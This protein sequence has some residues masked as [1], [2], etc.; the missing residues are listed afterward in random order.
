MLDNIPSSL[1]N[2]FTDTFPAL[3][4]TSG[5]IIGAFII[6]LIGYI[7]AK[8]V[9]RFVKNTLDALKIEK[10]GEKIR[11]VDMFA[12]LDFE[13]SDILSK[14]VFWLV[15]FLAIIVAT[16][17]LALPVISNGVGAIVAFLP[18]VLSALVIF[19]GGTFI[20][21]M[22]KNLISTTTQS[23]NIGAGKVIASIAFFFMVLIFAIM[24]LSQIGMPTEIMEK[25]LVI[26]IVAFLGAVA[27]GYG[28]SSKDLMANSVAGMYTKNK[29]KVG[30]TI[31]YKE[32]EGLIVDMDNNSATI[33]KDS[34]SKIVI[35]LSKFLTE[36]IEILNEPEPVDLAEQD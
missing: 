20:A 16:E 14:V 2:T 19:I 27:L 36:E 5:R 26:I 32:T 22:I 1:T 10:I 9:K 25:V 15:F 29:F 17:V 8:I 11:E 31:K 30:Q 23:M 6:L 21:N 12:K 35:P 7:I 34:G 3:I 13:L 33:K 18:K 28:L 24:A 4:N